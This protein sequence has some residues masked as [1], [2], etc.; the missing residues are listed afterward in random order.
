MP[1]H[2][3]S[4]TCN[5]ELCGMCARDIDYPDLKVPASH[6]V[7]EEIPFDDEMPNRHNMTQYVC[8]LH[9]MSI[10]GPAVDCLE[11]RG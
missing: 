6:K 1:N 3:V 4:T 7:G 10:M 8:C 5:G 2:P 9:Y 11:M